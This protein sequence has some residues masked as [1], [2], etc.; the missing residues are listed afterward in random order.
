MT[1][2]QTI[3]WF[4][5]YVPKTL[6]DKAPV[7]VLLHG[8]GQSMRKI[9]QEAAGGTREWPR[10]AESEGFLLLTPNGTNPRTNDTKGDQQNWNDLRPVNSNRDSQAD[11][12]G[13][14]REL[15]RWTETHYSMDSKRVYVTG[16][17]NGGMMTF[18]L[19]IE[20]PKLFAAG[21]A[22]IANLPED[23]SQYVAPRRTT[24]LMIANGTKDPLVKWE[25]GNVAGNRG[26]T[27]STDATVEWWTAANKTDTARKTTETLPD[28]D[29]GDGCRLHKTV[30]PAAP[31]GASVL[32]YRVEG[33]GHAMPSISHPL[34][35]KPLIRRFIGPVCRDVEGAKL[36][37]D[38]F[39]DK[40][41]SR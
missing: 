11:D 3:R 5:V 39:K 32:F 7:V 2:G 22:F 10:L 20:A 25:G 28:R 36:A 12:V 29:P 18:R 23:R 26:R 33:G 37:W 16:A 13:F 6:P 14:I 38:F 40:T 30:Y 27:L 8:G 24:P 19:L 35:D 41:R 4:R 17:S 15:L 21:A 31:G 34:A 9:F 1:F